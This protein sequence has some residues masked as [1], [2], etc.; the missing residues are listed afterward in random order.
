MCSTVALFV[1][2]QHGPIPASARETLLDV[3]VFFT[4]LLSLR[5]P[6]VIS[7]FFLKKHHRISVYVCVCDSR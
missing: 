4:R 3:W 6:E 5:L 2:E 7:L 1:A